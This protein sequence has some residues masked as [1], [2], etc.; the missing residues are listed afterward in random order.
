MKKGYVSIET[1]IV[2]A[3]VM[4]AGLAGVAVFRTRSG[5]AED[6]LNDAFDKAGLGN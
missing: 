1:V 3:I 6:K 5:A 2:A 4:L